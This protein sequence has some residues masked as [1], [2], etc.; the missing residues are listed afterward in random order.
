MFIF[1]KL[2]KWFVFLIAILKF[3]RTVFFHK[4]CILTT[5]LQINRKLKNK[6]LSIS[7]KRLLF[8]DFSKFSYSEFLPYVRYHYMPSEKNPDSYQKAWMH[9]L[10]NNDHHWEYHVN[11]Y[12][13]GMPLQKCIENSKEMKNE[14]LL[15]MAADLISAER[16]YKGNWPVKGN[17]IWVQNNI[18]KLGMHKE[19]KKKFLIFLCLLGYEADVRIGVDSNEFSL[20]ESNLSVF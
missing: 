2:R 14:A 18:P 4:Y 12:Y 5:G 3:V 20:I 10:K 15:E 16:A 6:N 17:W 7:L 9:H 19:S 8:H 13:T 1:Q 11:D